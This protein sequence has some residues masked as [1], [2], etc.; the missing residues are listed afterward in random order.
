MASTQARHK[1]SSSKYR[2]RATPQPTRVPHSE[3]GRP[4]TAQGIPQT[5][6]GALRA[7]MPLTMDE[8]RYSSSGTGSTAYSSDTHAMRT[9]LRSRMLRRQQVPSPTNA[10]I[11]ARQA[12]MQ[13]TAQCA[14]SLLRFASAPRSAQVEHWPVSFITERELLGYALGV[15]RGRLTWVR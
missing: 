2:H 7:H 11:R 8:P 6:V 4:G 5:S 3:E 9:A 13:G 10:A 1:L 14:T 15:C 12:Q